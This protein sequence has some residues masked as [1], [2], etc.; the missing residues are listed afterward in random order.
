[1]HGVPEGRLVV[2]RTS[3]GVKV[4]REVENQQCLRTVAPKKCLSIRT[5]RIAFTYPNL[6]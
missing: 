3:T 1:M 6:S 4:V 2:V 5:K